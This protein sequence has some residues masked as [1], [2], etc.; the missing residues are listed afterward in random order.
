MQEHEYIKVIDRVHITT[1]IE[2]LEKVRPSQ[3]IGGI[4]EADLKEMIIRLK[5]WEEELFR[6][7]DL[8]PDI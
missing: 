7:V 3:S 6:V 2:Q 1:A 4:S 5:E 8:T